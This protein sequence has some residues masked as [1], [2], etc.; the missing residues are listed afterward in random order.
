[1]APSPRSKTWRGTMY[2]P[3]EE[4]LE[5]LRTQARDENLHL[6]IRLHRE[7][8]AVSSAEVVIVFRQPRRAKANATEPPFAT[9]QATNF[10]TSWPIVRSEWN[11]PNTEFFPSACQCHM[12]RMASA[13]IPNGECS[14][15]DAAPSPKK[16]APK[17]RK[18]AAGACGCEAELAIVRQQ[19]AAANARWDR[20]LPVLQSLLTSDALQRLTDVP[21]EDSDVQTDDRDHDPADGFMAL[22]ASTTEPPSVPATAVEAVAGAH[23]EAVD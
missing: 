15:G 4:A 18:R 1:M 8:A 11:G 23:V 5:Q 20:A 22:S 13:P 6:A 17:K 7:G 12:C 16:A 9:W 3:T 2:Q 14:N 10:E 19:L 21:L